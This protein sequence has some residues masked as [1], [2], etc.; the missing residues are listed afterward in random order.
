MGERHL[1]RAD[2]QEQSIPISLVIVHSVF[3]QLRYMD[4]DVAL[5]H[6]QYPAQYSKREPKG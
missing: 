6:L 4:C 5:L 1:Q 2:K 3:N